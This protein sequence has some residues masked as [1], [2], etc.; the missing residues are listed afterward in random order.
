MTLAAPPDAAH[1]DD[2]PPES[3]P[4]PSAAPLFSMRVAYALAVVSG[5]TY[6]LGVPGV[7]VWPVA[8]VTMV[9]LL[10]ALSGRTPRDAAKLGL[11]AGFSGVAARLLLGCRGCSS[12]SAGWT[13]VCG[14]LM[15][16]MCA[17]PGWAARVHRV[18]HG[19]GRCASVEAGAIPFV[20][21][22]DDGELSL[23]VSS[24][25]ISPS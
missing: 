4:L 1:D 5:V 20:L 17:Y 24:P 9:P 18:A 15:I 13:A 19:A 10:L 16:A 2:A 8:L 6:F 23:S 7:N 11:V 22:F 3:V 12:A 25:G 14:L 21:S